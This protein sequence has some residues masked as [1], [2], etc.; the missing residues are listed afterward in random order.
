[1][2]YITFVPA[3]GF[4]TLVKNRLEKSLLTIIHEHVKKAQQYF[5]IIIG[6][7]HETVNYSL[8]FVNPKSGAHN[9]F[10]ESYLAKQKYRQNKMKGINGNVI[11]E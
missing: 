4:M 10:I 7:Q 2:V 1:M 11:E 6:L 3:Y 9:L 8:Y 5:R